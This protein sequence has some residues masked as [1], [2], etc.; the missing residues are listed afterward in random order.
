MNLRK[1]IKE[2]IDR[3][4]TDIHGKSYSNV[5]Y[6]G[7]VLEGS[8]ADRFE[9]EVKTRLDEMGIHV[10]EDWKKPDIYHMTIRLGELGLGAKM[11]GAIGTEVELQAYS[12]GISDK[13]IAVGV[14]GLYSKNDIQHV[15]FAFE[16]KPA[17]SNEIKHWFNIEEFS[18]NGVIA[19][20]ERQDGYGKLKGLDESFNNGIALRELPRQFDHLKWPLNDNQRHYLHDLCSVNPD[21]I[22]ES[23]VKSASKYL[24]I[25]EKNVKSILNTYNTY[26]PMSEAV[27]EPSADSRLR[28]G[29]SSMDAGL[30]A[31]E[32]NKAPMKSNK[33]MKPD[34]TT[35]TNLEKRTMEYAI[36]KNR[37]LNRADKKSEKE[38]YYESVYT[39]LMMYLYCELEPKDIKLN[40]NNQIQIDQEPL[41]MEGENFSMENTT[42]RRVN[43][44]IS[45]F[46][47]IF[48]SSFRISDHLDLSETT[49][50]CHRTIVEHFGLSEDKMFWCKDREVWIKP[51]QMGYERLREEYIQNQG[52]QMRMPEIQ[53]VDHKELLRKY[54]NGD[55]ISYNPNSEWI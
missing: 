9:S 8:E 2:E 42:Y 22:T 41:L 14:R 37:L 50:K 47:K 51:G 21:S 23:D 32:M 16:D 12:I 4:F 24:G 55:L 54:L 45:S 18:V 28:K 15:T 49:H 39:S 19:E 26:N 20:V 40:H 38:M 11:A 29:I 36:R 31:V 46:N 34:Q 52:Q 6:T 53:R 30:N 35:M 27:Y 13:A 43:E 1:I 48:N 7:V 5:E 44:L 25:P 17:D 33:V 3:V 10:P